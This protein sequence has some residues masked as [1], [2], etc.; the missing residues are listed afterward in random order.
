[1]QFSVLLPPTCPKMRSI[2]GGSS[3]NA[4]IRMGWPQLGHCKGR[5]S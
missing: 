4:M 3:M 2:T 5:H 1:M